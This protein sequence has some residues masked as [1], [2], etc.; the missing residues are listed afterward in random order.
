MGDTDTD[1]KYFE[2]SYEMSEITYTTLTDPKKIRRP[3]EAVLMTE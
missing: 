1:G 3:I 2:G